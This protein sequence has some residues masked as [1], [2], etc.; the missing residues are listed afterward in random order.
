MPAFNESDWRRFP[1][2]AQIAI[3]AAGIATQRL[4]KPT[5]SHDVDALRLYDDNLTHIGTIPWPCLAFWSEE[6]LIAYLEDALKSHYDEGTAAALGVVREQPWLV[7]DDPSG[8]M[9]T[10]PL[11]PSSEMRV[12]RMKAVPGWPDI[13]GRN[14][15][16][17]N[18]V[19]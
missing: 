1:H 7:T 2:E 14:P 16:L 12:H 11:G 19:E 17:W 18:R 15:S 8:E 13:D 3:N 6:A 5:A 10:I 4:S 9:I